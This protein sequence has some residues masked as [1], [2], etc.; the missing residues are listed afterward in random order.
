MISGI[1]NEMSNIAQAFI[2]FLVDLFEA[3]V[4]IVYT[5]GSGSDT[6]QLT[7]IGPLFLIGLV[8][9]LAMWALSYVRSLI[10]VRRG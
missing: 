7:V 1:F 10:R 3:V 5:P 2:S 4:G 8:T 9:G 6:G